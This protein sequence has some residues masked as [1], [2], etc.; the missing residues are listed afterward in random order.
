MG[1]SGS[2]DTTP[3]TEPVPEVSVAKKVKKDL[4]PPPIPAVAKIQQEMYNKMIP[5]TKHLHI[6]KINLLRSPF[7][8]F[9]FF[10]QLHAFKQFGQG[11][12]TLA[13]HGTSSKNYFHF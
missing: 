6:S 10:D 9:L 12:L 3:A 7:M 4:F 1:S 11:G 2:P 13:F 5:I 8:E